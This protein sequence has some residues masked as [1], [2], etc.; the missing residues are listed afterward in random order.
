[1][2]IDKYLIN[3]NESVKSALKKIDGNHLGIIFIE[4]KDKVI[5]VSTYGDI[6]R[7]MFKNNKTDSSVYKSMNKKFTY[8]LESEVTNELVLKSLNDK[9]KVIPVLDDN[10]SLVSVVSD[11]VISW[12]TTVHRPWG[13]YTTIVNSK[14]YLIKKIIIFPN[15]SIS[16][17]L[18]NYRS[19]HWIILEGVA[20]IQIGTKKIKL[21]SSESTYVPIKKKHKITNNSRKP[22]LILETQLG[23]KISEKDIVRFEDQYKR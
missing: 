8:L 17:Q 19:E 7:F 13:Y 15:Q 1:M 22:L 9:I 14:D 10:M 5:G 16:L 4:D 3:K 2:K 20:D 6:R 18:H 12:N 21:K 11:K 23:T